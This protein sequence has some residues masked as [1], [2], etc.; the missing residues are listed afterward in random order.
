MNF[1]DYD[2]DHLDNKQWIYKTIQHLL[3]VKEE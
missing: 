2:I 3:G 1:S